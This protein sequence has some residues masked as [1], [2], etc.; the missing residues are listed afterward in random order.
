M[1]RIALIMDGWKRFFTYAWPSGILQRLHETEEE[2]NLYIFNSSGDW[3]RD[4]DYNAGEYNIY[5][6]PDLN[7]FDGIV[8]D[9]NNIR[10]PAVRKYVISAAKKTGKPVISVANEI[11]DFYYVGID[12]YHAIYEV[13]EHMHQIH[14]CHKF[15]FIMGP[16]D[17]YENE[18]RVKALKDYMAE[19]GI[20]YQENDFYYDSF[21]YQCGY[22][23]FHKMY[24]RHGHHISE[25]V[26]CANDNI[27][28]GVCEA[29]VTLGLKVPD[30][31]KVSGFDNFD[32][33]SFYSPN[34]TTVAHIREEVGYLCADIFIRLWKGQ[35][36]PRFNYTGTQC[37]FW[38]S[39]GCKADIA[40][41][42]V[43][44][45]KDQIMYGIETT[46][47]EEQ[48]LSL[49]YELLQCSTVREMTKWI[50]ACI[51]SMKCDAMY[52]IVDEHL[53][54]YKRQTDYLDLNMI[55]DEELCLEGYPERMNIEFA[56]VDGEL[57]NTEGKTISSL[58]PVFDYEKG[59]T[60]FLFMPM[61]F[62]NRTVGYFVIRNAVY[63]M[64]KQYLFQ[65]INTLT[66]AME[67]LHKKEKLEYMNKML[68]EL[69]VRDAMTGL[70]NHMGYQK[71][72]WKLFDSKK[73]KKENMLILF[74]DLDRL[75][76]INDHYGHE[77]GDDAIK[78]IAQA[79]L[80][81]CS[82]DSVPVRTGGDEFLIIQQA[83][84]DE[85]GE[86]LIR[87]IRQEIAQKKENRK[88]AYPL[89]VSIGCVRTD[90]DTD[91]T[92][93]DYVREA[94]EIMYAEKLAK[95]VNR[96]E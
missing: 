37:I 51:P 50:P 28:V 81:N 70:Y 44:H 92:L 91:K 63:L 7:D 34:I 4:D 12:N 46:D 76:Y 32:K 47:F 11:E 25:A 31:F 2:V 67:N 62:H 66:S 64:E 20:A 36:V 65:I 9:L 89:T 39:C 10:Y 82:K 43:Q 18:V 27:A 15:W 57:H 55:E 80:H 73:K 35:Q 56:Y 42:H 17:N 22:Q 23:G 60:D 61:H 85:S 40:I 53:Y 38:E 45:A 84:G 93:D 26:I 16:E 72:A 33:A 77:Q 49:E 94:D 87:L 3:S 68:T 95:K 59:G 13:I 5:H 30:D 48:I 6:L 14:H 88:L 90:M 52:L 1:K 29:A 74:V 83:S 96:K 54:D 21:E 86:Q 78:I 41:D 71:L 19:Q 24:E 58:F 69:Y 75:K 8:L 79:I